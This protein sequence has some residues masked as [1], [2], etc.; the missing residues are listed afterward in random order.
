M[1]LVTT[2][3]SSRVGL[4]PATARIRCSRVKPIAS[5]KRNPLESHRTLRAPTMGLFSF[6]QYGFLNESQ[7]LRLQRARSHR[8][9][10]QPPDSA[11]AH[12][13]PPRPL[14]RHG[15]LQPQANPVCFNDVYSGDCSPRAV[16][17][18]AH[19][20]PLQPQI[21]RR[22]LGERWGQQRRLGNGSGGA[23]STHCPRCSYAPN[24][25]ITSH[26]QKQND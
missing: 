16:P 17:W 15:S 11:R 2:R 19:G 24:S 6:S 26:S 23:L 1:K 10:R 3:D 18:S 4:K 25:A 12:G 8:C 22:R 9:H 7:R 20:C 14:E 13:N 21:S 5:P